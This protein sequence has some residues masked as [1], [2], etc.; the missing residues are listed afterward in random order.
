MI[1]KHKLDEDI[2]ETDPNKEP[3]EFKATGIV[4]VY[5]WNT[6]TISLQI[7]SSILLCAIIKRLVTP[8]V[9]LPFE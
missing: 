8:V 1:Y 7:V 2:T 9:W 3:S 5:L 4:T 6:D